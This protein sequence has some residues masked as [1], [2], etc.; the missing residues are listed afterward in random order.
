MPR[1]PTERNVKAVPAPPRRHLVATVTTLA[2]AVM[3]LGLAACG[4]DAQTEQV[5]TPGEGVNNRE[6]TVDVLH[7]LIVSG[8]DG[9]GTVIAGL[10]NN[11]LQAGDA[12]VGVQGTGEDQSVTV[13]GAS[14][15]V[16]AGGFVQLADEGAVGVTGEQVRP[17]EFVSLAFS[18]QSGDNLTLDVPVVT[19]DGTYEDVPLPSES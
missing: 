17:G 11:D 7:A 19:A 8:E 14:V 6:G 10:S 13:E 2:A 16:P 12:L 5:Y 15:D 9:S 3:S 18:F 4:F 1:G